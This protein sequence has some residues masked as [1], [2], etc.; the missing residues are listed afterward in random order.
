MCQQKRMS[1]FGTE[2]LEIVLSNIFGEPSKMIK[3]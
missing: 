3:T 1:I 2:I